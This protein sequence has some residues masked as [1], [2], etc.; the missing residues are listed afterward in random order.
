MQLDAG[1]HPD[2]IFILGI[3]ERSGT[4]FL[5]H[6]L[7]LHPDCE[8]GGIVAEDYLLTRADLLVGYADAVY[9]TFNRDWRVDEIIGPRG[10]LLRHLGDGLIRFLNLQLD[11]SSPKRLVTKTPSVR[12]LASF[13]TL[14]PRARL[15]I[16]VRDGRAVVESGH[17]SF[18]WNYE[19]GMRLWRDAAREIIAFERTHR[20]VGHQYMIVKYED[21]CSATDETLR[22]VFTFLDLDAE[23]YDFESARR[24][25]V[26]GSSEVRAGE[27]E[28]VHWRPVDRPDDFS[29]LARA[30]DWNRAMHERFNWIAGDQL[31]HFGY[32]P[33]IDPSHRLAWTIRNVWRDLQWKARIARQMLSGVF[34]TRT[35]P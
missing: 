18:D 35:S 26:F 9:D 17:K 2:P 25:P 31:T 30:G 19:W 7:A 16:I 10:V 32:R 24:L 5:F 8:S 13:F 29:P 12:N 23:A 27:R 20:D 21:L 3:T 22:R 11:G 6:L 14:F 28:S 33:R 15:L 34:T 4:N 1:T